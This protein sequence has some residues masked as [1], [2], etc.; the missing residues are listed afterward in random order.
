MI[1]SVR[2]PPTRHNL[3]T[4][5]IHCPNAYGDPGVLAPLLYP[6]SGL[7]VYE[8]AVVPHYID[9]DTPFI[10]R[11]RVEGL[12]VLDVGVPCAEFFAELNQYS[13]ILS[14]SLHGI[15]L[16]HAYGLR[17]AWIEPSEQ[18]LGNGF[19]FF[20][21]YLNIGILPEDVNRH[22][23]SYEANISAL[24]DSADTGNVGAL[25][26]SCLDGIEKTKAQLAKSV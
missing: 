3:E 7:K 12:P 10:D 8:V 15:I 17:A 25:Q 2:G 23:V 13:V 20:D 18:V 21:Y 11:C 4:Q 19:K 22:R 5:G 6:Y 9:R 24:I 26:A 1:I 16:A 14:S